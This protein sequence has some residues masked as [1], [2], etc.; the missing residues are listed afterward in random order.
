M[1]VLL[2]ISHAIAADVAATQTLIDDITLQQHTKHTHSHTLRNTL[3]HTY[4]VDRAQLLLRSF[5]GNCR[6]GG[7]RG[8][9]RGGWDVRKGY[10]WGRGQPGWRPQS[11]GGELQVVGRQLFC[12]QRSI[13]FFACLF[14]SINF[15]SSLYVCVC[16]IRSCVSEGVRRM[17]MGHGKAQRE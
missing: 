4:R 17:K 1:L 14:F 13:I 5:L 12:W 16:G 3:R 7:V 2:R 15:A 10:M 6:W 9:Y 11:V 8:G